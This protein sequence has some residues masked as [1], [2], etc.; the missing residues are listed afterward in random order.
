[1]AFPSLPA[2]PE[3]DLAARWLFIIAGS[4]PVY[5]RSSMRQF[6]FGTLD[7]HKRTAESKFTDADPAADSNCAPSSARDHAVDDQHDYR[8]HHRSDQARAF[9]RP[10]PTERLT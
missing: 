5:V 8:S 1:M 10:V 9:T 3:T 4:T 7:L 6:D 2:L